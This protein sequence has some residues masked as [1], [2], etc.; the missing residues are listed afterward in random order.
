[1]NEL[2]CQIGKRVHLMTEKKKFGVP[3]SERMQRYKRILSLMPCSDTDAEMSVTHKRCDAS[4]AE[5]RPATS[6]INTVQADVQLR[7]CL[8]QVP[9]AVRECLRTNF[10]FF[11][12]LGCSG[13]LH[14]W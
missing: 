6:A 11:A 14:A 13:L 8:H 12:A 5:T 1:L 3:T 7:P 4:A 9:L 10:T 2:V